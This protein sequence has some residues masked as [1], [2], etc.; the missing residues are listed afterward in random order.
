MWP[1][2]FRSSKCDKR[3][4]PDNQSTKKSISTIGPTSSF[5][6]SW[7]S[8]RSFD[9]HHLEIT[10]SKKYFLV[11]SLLLFFVIFHEWPLFCYPHYG[12]RKSV[13]KRWTIQPLLWILP[14]DQFCY[15]VP[16]VTIFT[17]QSILVTQVS[18][19]RNNLV[20]RP[21]WRTAVLDS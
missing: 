19:F 21:C 18:Q 3:D 11:S 10:C 17:S 1:H 2:Q 12:Q 9:Q 15:V 8:R 14:V 5:Q 20:R 13:K 7:N 4:L 6:Y 16:E